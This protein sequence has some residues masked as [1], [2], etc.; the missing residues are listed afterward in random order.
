[1]TVVG[2]V[3]KPKAENTKADAVSK[4]YCCE[5]CGKVLK[6]KSALSNHIKAHIKRGE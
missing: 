5:K 2:L 6:S 3:C 1:M 4:S